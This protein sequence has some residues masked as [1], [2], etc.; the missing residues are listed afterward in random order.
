MTTA[1]RTHIGEA[2]NR[3]A[4]SISYSV[5]LAVLRSIPTVQRV[6]SCTGR[7]AGVSPL[8]A[9]APRWMSRKIKAS[10]LY[11]PAPAETTTINMKA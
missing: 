6:G 9:H 10:R 2:G 5:A 8:K 7:S 11:G 4:L 3:S 1:R